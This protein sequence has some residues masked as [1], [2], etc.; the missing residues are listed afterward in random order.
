LHAFLDEPESLADQA[1]IAVHVAGCSRCHETLNRLTDIEELERWRPVFRQRCN[2]LQARH[3]RNRADTPEPEEAFLLDLKGALARKVSMAPGV[4]A[5]RETSPMP[6]QIGHYTIRRR[7]G[8]GGM[9]VV[10]EGYDGRLKRTVAIKM[11]RTVLD[12]TPQMRERLHQEA[13]TVARL[14]HPNIVQIHDVGEHEEHPYLVL[15]YV[16][17]GTLSDQIAGQPQPPMLAARFVMSLARAIHHAHQEGIVHRDL[18]PANVLLEPI[19]RGPKD[20]PGTMSLD[21]VVP[22]IADFGL[23]KLSDVSSRMTRVEMLVG[24]PAYMAPEQA[25]A[26]GQV[27]PATDIHALGAILYKFLTGRPPFQ[28]VGLRETLEMVRL[29]DP[30]PPTLLQPRVPRDLETICLKCLQK[31]PASRYATAAA[32][33]DDLERFLAQRP[34][35]ARPAGVV[36]RMWRWSRRNPAVASLAAAISLLVVAMIVGLSIGLSQLDQA[37][38]KLKEVNDEERRAREFA[39]LLLEDMTSPEALQFL[40]TQPDLRPEQRQFLSKVVDYYRQFTATP[41]RDR[42]SQERRALALLRMSVFLHRLG[43][44]EEAIRAGQQAAQSYRELVA[45]HPAESAFR[46]KLAESHMA[47]GSALG[48][49]HR[50]VEAREQL[51]QSVQVWERLAA[52]HPEVPD[53]RFQLGRER[54]MLGIYSC[55]LNQFGEAENEC[56][57]SLAILEPLVQKYPA[58]PGYRLGLALSHWYM[59]DSL[60]ALGRWTEAETEA[61]RSVAMLEQLV[62]EHPSQFKY[63][64]DLATIHHY[65]SERL[66]TQLRW[67]KAEEHYAGALRLRRQLL[68][69]YPGVA[70]YRLGLARSSNG[71]GAIFWGRNE[72]A[73]AEP[74]F[75]EA[76]AI[77]EGLIADFPKEI[78]YRQELGLACGLR[79]LVLPEHK[80]AEAVAVLTRGI[81]LLE[82]IVASDRPPSDARETLL[83]SYVLRARVLEGQDR[84]ATAAGDWRRACD[85]TDCGDRMPKPSRPISRY[86]RLAISLARPLLQLRLDGAIRR[87]RSQALAQARKGN[88][89]AA[90][91]AAAEMGKIKTLPANI[92]YD[93]ARIHSRCAG[94]AKADLNTRDGYAKQAMTQLNRAREVGAFNWSRRVQEL[95]E[96][97]DFSSLREREDFKQ[98][99]KKVE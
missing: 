27:S 17:G 12:P 82:P 11:L 49:V 58:V 80:R 53:H 44:N 51:R 52:D 61:Q 47:L 60:L 42:A 25:V 74:F 23:A 37:N 7:L 77:Y 21:S 55:V 3:G 20:D 15:E 1:A 59:G 96:S 45:D 29:H 94:I 88:H 95:K 40:E 84:H 79:G 54:A 2:A 16:S 31:E 32:L 13:E 41:A 36:E 5:R 92:V 63:R 83:F 35:L 8:S 26:M 6:T 24:T 85:L 4:G 10:F 87:A 70:D 73:K 67:A 30:V 18:K 50:D 68:A 69:E 93:L 81:Q 46:L 48:S 56:R 66:M 76:A 62:K 72:P 22:K 91:D 9:G 65:Y 97:R 14:R 75:R 38:R 34:I 43:A 78:M 39:Q 99:L 28:E 57:Q 64:A 98:L 86:V 19:E 89:E 71:M 90:A 33:A